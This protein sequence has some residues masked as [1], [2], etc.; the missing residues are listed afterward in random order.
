MEDPND[1]IYFPWLEG[2]LSTSNEH[3]VL[4]NQSGL[5]KAKTEATKAIEDNRIFERN[6]SSAL[7]L[8]LI[9]A[10]IL[11]NQRSL[12]DAARIR[13]DVS[14]RRRQ[15]KEPEYPWKLVE[16]LRS[17]AKLLMI[18]GDTS[19]SRALL[20]EAL[21]ICETSLKPENMS[22]A[23][24]P[25]DEHLDASSSSGANCLPATEKGG[26]V[27]E[28]TQS[29][30]ADRSHKRDHKSRSHSLWNIVSAPARY[31]CGRISHMKPEPRG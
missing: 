25:T 20:K 12:D 23:G 31:L 4:G 6:D 30:L 5:D 3:A 21:D 18:S 26:R 14:V 2:L 7:S 8:Q 28:G 10:Q 1:A 13:Q 22:C 27:V 9:Y 24:R 19:E 11:Y 16:A 17:Y 15:N 29:T